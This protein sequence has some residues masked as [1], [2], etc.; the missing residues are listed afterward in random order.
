MNISGYNT[1]NIHVGS[2]IIE[3]DLTI[4]GDII[5]NSPSPPPDPTG[6]FNPLD[7]SL[8]ANNFRITNL[9]STVD[10]KD[11]INK[12]EANNLY[13]SK[14]GGTMAGIIYMN[15][16]RISNVGS[17]IDN[18]DAITFQ[19]S[20][21]LYL[22]KTGG[23]MTGDINMGSQ[24]IINISAPQSG[25]D[26]VNRNYLQANT[27][28]NPAT[29]TQNMNNN[30][31]INLPAPL[32]LTE[33]V[34]VSYFQTNALMNPANATLNMNNNRII[35]VPLALSLTDAVSVNYLQ[36]NALINP[37]NANLNMNNFEIQEIKTLRGRNNVPLNIIL[38]S[39][40]S[41]SI[42]GGEIF[43]GNARIGTVAPPLFGDD[44][45]TKDYVDGLVGSPGKLRFINSIA[46]LG[47]PLSI[48]GQLRYVIPNDLTYYV[49]SS[50]TI[51]YGFSF[52]I[53]TEITGNQNISITFNEAINDITGFY[54]RN[55][56]TTITNLTFIYGGGNF[57]GF[58]DINN[59]QKGLFDCIDLTKTK[60]FRLLNCNFIR[61]RRFGVVLGY[62]NVNINDNVIDG[63]GNTTTWYN[64]LV[65]TQ[66]L[67][68]DDY[69]YKVSGSNLELITNSS[70]SGNVGSITSVDI[71]K[72]GTDVLAQQY[73]F[74]DDNGYVQEQ[75]ITLFTFGGGENTTYGKYMD[76]SSTHLVTSFTNTATQ[77]TNLIIYVRQLDS[78]YLF[79]QVFN[80]TTLNITEVPI[81]ISANIIAH[82]LYDGTKHVI[83]IYNLVLGTWTKVQEVTTNNINWGR[84]SI[85][86]LEHPNGNAYLIVGYPGFAINGGFGAVNVYERLPGGSFV[87]NGTLPNPGLALSLNFGRYVSADRNMLM[88]SADNNT[89]YLTRN[90]AIAMGTFISS[91]IISP[92]EDK[93]SF[94]QSIDVQYNVLDG[95]YRML[96]GDPALIEANVIS[97]VI[98]TFTAGKLYVY[99][100]RSNNAN[101]NTNDLLLETKTQEIN[102]PTFLMNL[103]NNIG[104]TTGLSF[105]KFSQGESF[106]V[107]SP[108]YNNSIG[109]TAI[110]R[111]KDNKYFLGQ[112]MTVDQSLTGDITGTTVLSYDD[113]IFIASPGFDSGVSLNQGRITR[114]KKGVLSAQGSIVISNA[115]VGEIGQFSK[116]GLCLQDSNT[117]EYN[118]NNTYAFS[119][120][121]DPFATNSMLY[122]I[123][124]SSGGI[125]AVTI[126]GNIFSPQNLESAIDVDPTNI[127]NLATIT[128]NTFI[129]EGGTEPLIKYRD[130]DT[131][132]TFN[133]P[134]VQ[135]FEIE[136]NA[137]EIN[138][139]PVLRHILG[140]S[141]QLQGSV[142]SPITYL[143][144]EVNGIFDNSKRFAVRCQIQ[145][146]RQFQVGNY[147]KP[148]DLGQALIVYAEPITNATYQCYWITDFTGPITSGG[149]N[150]GI[151]EVAYNNPTV[152]STGSNFRLGVL[153]GEVNS[154][155]E[156]V[157]IDKDPKDMV[158][159]CSLSFTADTKD[160]THVFR[161]N[162]ASDGVN[163]LNDASLE[164]YIVT[165]RISPDVMNITLVDSFKFVYGSKFKIEQKQNT[166]TLSVRI[167]D[168]IITAQ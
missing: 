155:Y 69:P 34:T 141:Q 62:D 28:A 146:T 68:M 9:G 5:K 67:F 82:R 11:A 114:F 65:S 151:Q 56:N 14:S 39:G 64:S 98:T 1:D 102:A 92:D 7:G 130:S 113:T 122:F 47:T 3:G 4:D 95:E 109:N 121:Q 127:I 57:A 74:I 13:L 163:Y 144:T 107:G 154:F 48:D 108:L 26:V 165:T 140:L 10:L 149:I 29:T 115:T 83:F 16:N 41:L 94:G 131:I 117:L 55:Q 135:K 96:I 58:N 19:Q 72:R 166:T 93:K 112:F 25:N 20:N 133:H 147:I 59:V 76:M 129:R 33:P 142:W 119:G 54:S 161:I 80:T 15:N 91:T 116:S 150:T 30:R 63:G 49:T 87:L 27:L 134:S 110:Y 12:G 138:S 88:T 137:G 8:N 159:S 43:C 139:T 164:T 78:S 45:A 23:T 89:V 38:G 66:P 70:V 22:A 84:Y 60:R 120:T 24:R 111:Y 143:N 105:S 125:N 35:N 128:G 75:N 106:V 18:T 53:N 100:Y 118:N 103:N 46:D 6:V 167:R 132:N 157:Y 168:G 40:G 101:T 31:I 153:S 2:V 73:T 123:A 50:L 136:S 152:I 158:I 148:N 77:Q 32:A 126:D 162:F 71:Y 79:S 85:K 52:G 51:T 81:S 36:A 160:R 124:P 37:A 86:V 156:Y 42:S 104:F 21:N 61:S 97:N 44:V 17:A 145:S 90:Y 99:Y